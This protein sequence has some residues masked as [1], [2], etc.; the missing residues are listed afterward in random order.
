MSDTD[1]LDFFDLS[2]DSSQAPPSV[3]AM[4]A[5]LVGEAGFSYDSGAG[6]YRHAR[7]GV[8]VGAEAAVAAAIGLA[9]DGPTAVRNAIAEMIAA[10][11]AA[12][13]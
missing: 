12:G 8:C 1:P 10:A 3:R 6:R 4:H 9:D 13:A 2:P 5:W 11:E 7:T